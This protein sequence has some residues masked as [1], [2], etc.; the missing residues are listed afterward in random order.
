MYARWS[1]RSIEYAQTWESHPRAIDI[2]RRTP[3]MAP[4]KAVVILRQSGVS[5]PVSYTTAMMK[6][7]IK[8]I[9]AVLIA[10]GQPSSA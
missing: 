5:Y 6:L 7:L 4:V 9:S 3:F 10:T 2:H 1:L 8:L